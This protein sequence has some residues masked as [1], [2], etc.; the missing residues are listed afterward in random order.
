MHHDWQ[1]QRNALNHDWL[2]NEFARHL[3]A[4]IARIEAP[5]VDRSRLTEFAVQDWHRWESKR[6]ELIALLDSAEDELSPR[7]LVLGHDSHWQW[8]AQTKLRL[9]ELVHLLWLARTLVREKVDEARQ[10]LADADRQYRE[11]SPMVAIDDSLDAE[12]LRKASPLFR[13]F[14]RAVED[15]ADRLSR[16]PHKVQ[17]V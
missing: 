6:E 3:R 15:L 8:Q 17:V 2:K 10:V 14:E 12:R 4:F 13:A 16:L 11:L 7:Q 9:A 5:T 1:R